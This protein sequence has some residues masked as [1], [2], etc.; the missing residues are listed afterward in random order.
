MKATDQEHPLYSNEALVKQV[1]DTHLSQGHTVLQMFQLAG[2]EKSH[3]RQ[4]LD[5]IGI[6]QHAHI[7]SL[8]CGIAGMEHY[9]KTARPDLNFDLLNLTET[10][11]NV[12]SCVGKKIVGDAETYVSNHKVDIVLLAY[13]LGHVNPIITL[14]NALNSLEPNGEIIIYDVF[15]GTETF[16]RELFYTTPKLQ[17]IEAVA[18]NN[19]MRLRVS[20]QGRFPLSEFASKEV[21]WVATHVTPA[22]FV[23][24]K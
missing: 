3:S 21:P 18:V 13:M 22:L 16:D 15:D 20:L 24:T 5:L 1:T 17:E 4:L 8:G 14:S 7:L 2:G 6:K 19:N 12:S 10:Q 23:L 9:W 11:L